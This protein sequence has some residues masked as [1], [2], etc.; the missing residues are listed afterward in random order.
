ML[1]VFGSTALILLAFG[2]AAAQG[3]DARRAGARPLYRLALPDKSWALDLDLS[4]FD[5]PAGAA[6]GLE[7][8]HAAPVES[9][10][11]DG[12]E[13]QLAAFRRFGDRDSAPAVGVLIRMTAGH[14]GLDA[15][16]LR[17]RILKRAG[18]GAVAL[19]GVKRW[20]YKGIPVARYSTQLAPLA[21]SPPQVYGPKVRSLEAY[22]V[23]EDV[24]IT[25]A[26]IAPELD[27]RGEQSFNSLLDSV[28]FADTTAPATSF[29]LY[30]AGR[31]RL[32][33]K[34]SRGASEM[35]SKALDIERRAR[36]LDR[37]TWRALVDNLVDSYA[38]AGEFAR[39]KEVLDYAAAEDP[40]D[41]GIQYALGRYHAIHGD[42]DNTLAHL[43]KA[44]GSGAQ[45]P[46]PARDPAF[47]RFRKDE[48]FRK[49][50]KTLKQ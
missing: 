26:F 21:A 7:K 37:A 20:E 38:A 16:G 36:T 35:F 44:F 17:E 3:A 32:L 11:G 8:R 41:P 42:L 33:R 18:G 13:Y 39:V 22:F 24:W 30:H 50:L 19:S 10:S 31:L 6:V 2:S 15:E 28:K 40:A 43:E 4:D 25:V 12:R 23:K 49:T 34:D 1:R 45:L 46:D 48:R 9:L 27:E 29:D 14:T 47:G 5:L